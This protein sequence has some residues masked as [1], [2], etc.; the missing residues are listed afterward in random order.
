MASLPCDLF[1]TLVYP[2]YFLLASPQ[3]ASY[4]SV[5]ASESEYTCRTSILP[6]SGLATII[7]VELGLCIQEYVSERLDVAQAASPQSRTC[8]HSYI[9]LSLAP[10]GISYQHQPILQFPHLLTVPSHPLSEVMF[11]TSV[12]T[13]LLLDLQQFGEL[14]CPPTCI[15][16]RPQLGTPSLYL[17]STPGHEAA[18]DYAPRLHLSTVHLTLVFFSFLCSFAVRAL[19][20]LGPSLS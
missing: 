8:H 10:L 12:P 7:P 6:S 16:L 3:K 4:N 20:S 18:G 1:S 15:Q 2:G 19:L 17:T 14:H 13:P 5:F 11:L 9:L